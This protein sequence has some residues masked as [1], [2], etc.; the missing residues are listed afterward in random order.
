MITRSKNWF[1]IVFSYLEVILFLKRWKFCRFLYLKRLFHLFNQ[2]NFLIPSYFITKE[3]KHQFPKCLICEMRNVLFF[4]R[5]TFFKFNNLPYLFLCFLY[6]CETRLGIRKASTWKIPTHQTPPWKIPTR[7]IS[8]QKIS[9]WNIPINVFNYSHPSF[10]NF[11]IFH[12]CQRHH[13]YFT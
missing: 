13:W 1:V 9:A 5:I 7:K 6:V 12:Y 2:F 10:L 8:T 4:I 3:W 11:L